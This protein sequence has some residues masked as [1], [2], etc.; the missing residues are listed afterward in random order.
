MKDDRRGILAALAASVLWGLF[1]AWFNLLSAVPAPELLA[2]RIL[3]TAAGF[4]LLLALGGRLG[5][6]AAL[7]RSPERGRAIAAAFFIA[8]NWGTYIWAVTSGHAIE[9]S[10]GYFIFPLTAVLFGVVFR[11]ESLRP[12]ARVAVALAAVGVLVLTIGLGVPPLIALTLALS[13]GAYS[14]MKSRIRAAAEVSVTFEALVLAPLALAWLA[15]VGAT[16]WQ[17]GMHFGGDSLQSALLIAT[18][19]ISGVPLILFSWG[20]SRIRLSTLGMVQYMNPTLQ[21]LYAVIVLGE[22]L[23]LW[24]MIAFACIWAGLA[25]FSVAAVAAERRG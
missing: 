6:V 16:G 21:G 9:A 19:L 7:W 22:R 5:E 11:G 18:G 1:P 12:A 3:W 23:T 17:G 20:S 8:L 25:V 4:A 24:H 15:A 13:F 10:L 2:H 14:L